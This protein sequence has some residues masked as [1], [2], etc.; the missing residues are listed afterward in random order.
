[1]KINDPLLA[2][3]GQKV[4]G[5]LYSRP[6][7]AAGEFGQHSALVIYP[8]DPEAVDAMLAEYGYD[9]LVDAGG[10]AHLIIA[11]Y[12]E[13]SNLVAKVNYDRDSPAVYADLTKVADIRTPA[14]M[15]EL[16]YISN[17]LSGV[18]NFNSAGFTYHPI[19]NFFLGQQRYGNCN[20]FSSGLIRHSGGN[21]T[22]SK[23]YGSVNQY[24]GFFSPA[25]SR[26]YK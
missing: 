11:G 9:P 24:P 8:T 20:S 18:S 10:K 19:P 12:K 15:S 13:G 17:A 22:I 16:T 21:G 6:T 25:P 3:R 26:F 14:G 2:Q 23:W 1:M 4:E 7:D 5:G